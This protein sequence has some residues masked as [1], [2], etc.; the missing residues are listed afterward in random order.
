MLPRHTA[1]AAAGGSASFSASLSRRLGGAASGVLCAV[2]AVLVLRG[3]RGGKVSETGCMRGCFR[4][5]F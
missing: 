4:H 3:V 1:A 5:R 2:M